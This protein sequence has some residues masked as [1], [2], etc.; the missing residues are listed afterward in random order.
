MASSPSAESLLLRFPDQKKRTRDEDRA[1]ATGYGPS[2]R[3]GL[4]QGRFDHELPPE[5]PDKTQGFGRRRGAG[6]G[7]GRQDHFSGE[8]KDKG[9]E[10][11]DGLVFHHGKNNNGR[12]AAKI[13]DIFFEGGRAGFV[14]GAVEEDQGISGKGLQASLPFD[15]LDALDDL[16]FLERSPRPVENA[17]RGDGDAGVRSLML[18]PKPG[19]KT[20]RFAVVPKTKNV[21]PSSFLRGQAAV[22][23]VREEDGG[24]FFD[25][26][27]SDDPKSDSAFYPADDGNARLDD[28]RLLERDLLQRRPQVFLVVLEMFVM[29]DTSGVTTFVASNRPPIP[30]SSTAISTSFSRK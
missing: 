2:Q 19:R 1:A 10:A 24:L 27:R 15:P 29:T 5:R 14:M 26:A 13:L 18:S 3:H 17:R 12:P 8:G 28:P 11:L 16:F 25:R 20:E 7:H 22:P 9:G 4:F 23:A 30:V 6:I 21:S